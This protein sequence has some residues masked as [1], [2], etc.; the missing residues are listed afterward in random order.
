MAQP[1]GFALGSVACTGR[2]M[3][4]TLAGT[5]YGALQP[6]CPVNNADEPQRGTCEHRNQIKF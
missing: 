6:D 1:K 2:G 5:Y 4:L 3:E